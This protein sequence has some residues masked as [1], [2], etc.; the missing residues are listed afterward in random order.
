MIRDFV[1]L[2]T[3]VYVA[4]DEVWGYPVYVDNIPLGDLRSGCTAVAR[5][6]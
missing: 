3:Y 6:L 2:C 1:D 5:A 4:T